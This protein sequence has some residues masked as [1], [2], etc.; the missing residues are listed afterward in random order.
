MQHSLSFFLL[1]FALL[2]SPAFAIA[3]E[4]RVAVYLRSGER[5]EGVVEETD[6]KEFFTLSVEKTLIKVPLS[7]IERTVEL[8]RELKLLLFCH[9]DFGVAHYIRER[10]E[11][12]TSPDELLPLSYHP[13]VST[14][15]ETDFVKKS[16]LP[17]PLSSDIF[18]A[19]ENETIEPVELDGYFYVVKVVKSRWVEPHPHKPP[20][21]V[22]EQHPKED[23]PEKPKDESKKEEAKEEATEVA[24]GGVTLSILPFSP[25]NGEAEIQNLP[26][27]VRIA[28]CSILKKEFPD[29]RIEEKPSAEYYITGEVGAK[30]DARS[31]R[32]VLGSNSRG[33]LYDSGLQTLLKD[34]LEEMLKALLEELTAK[35]KETLD[36][37]ASNQNNPKGGTNRD[38]R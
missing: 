18:S 3:E 6:E 37:N 23:S 25:K 13:S 35:L 32:L 4:I 17:H 22:G 8:V 5:L 38:N 26:E 21:K 2:L 36:A 20:Q 15:G 27:K 33:T 29:A 16:S 34:E 14:K 11:H 24:E 12:G 19:E 31:L 1:F 10:L 28:T 30:D 9:P 7:A